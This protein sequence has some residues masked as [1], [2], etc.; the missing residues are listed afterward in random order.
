MA[1]NTKIMIFLIIPA[2]FGLVFFIGHNIVKADEMIAIPADTETATI[3]K[4]IGSSTIASFIPE[5]KTFN[6]IKADVMADVSGASSDD[7]QAVVDTLNSDNIK[8]DNL[9]SK[10]AQL[11]DA[12]KNK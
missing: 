10:Y 1:N 5:E 3:E 2:S 4:R 12:C 7:I 6:E 11:Y 9:A 8:K